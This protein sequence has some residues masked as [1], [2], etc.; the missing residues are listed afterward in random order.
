ML[1]HPRRLK[2]HDPKVN[3]AVGPVGAG[4]IADAHEEFADDLT[5]REYEILFE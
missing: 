3:G 4:Q 1:H 2:A 5:A